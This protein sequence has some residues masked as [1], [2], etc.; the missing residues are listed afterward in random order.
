MRNKKEEEGRRN[1]E[2]QEKRVRNKKKWEEIE[3]ERGEKKSWKGNKKYLLIRPNGFW[4]CDILAKQ[5]YQ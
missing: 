3:R 1:N 4:Y 5:W 2:K